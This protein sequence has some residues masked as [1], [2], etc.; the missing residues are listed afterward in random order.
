ML[1]AFE[2]E[3][4]A[5]VVEP[6]QGRVR[7]FVRDCDDA[8][9]ARA[10]GADLLIVDT[11]PNADQAS[12][13]AAREADLILIP[14]RPAAFDLEAVETTIDLA[15]LAKKPFAVVLNCAPPKRNALDSA[16]VMEG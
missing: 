13:K 1:P 15:H 3:T 8:E 10:N 11:A 6:G 12:L 14:C 9:A 5:G 4:V 7:V 16:I 2:I